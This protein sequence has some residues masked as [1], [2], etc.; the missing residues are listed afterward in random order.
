MAAMQLM[1]S[2]VRVMNTLTEATETSQR[3]LDAEK[4]RK[5]GGRV[6]TER[7]LR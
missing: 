6:A 5:G 2:L 7:A 1:T 4:K 3:Q